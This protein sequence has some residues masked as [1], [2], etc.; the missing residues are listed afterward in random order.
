MEIASGDD[1]ARLNQYEW[2]VRGAIHLGGND[3]FRRFN[4]IPWYAMNLE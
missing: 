4:R 3:F 1:L 2:V